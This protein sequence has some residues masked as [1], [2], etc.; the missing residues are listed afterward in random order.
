MLHSHGV[1]ADF[2]MAERTAETRKV[3]DFGKPTEKRNSHEQSYSERDLTQENIDLTQ[4]QHVLI[5]ET[6]HLTTDISVAG[7]G[8]RKTKVL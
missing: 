3:L 8:E 1:L 7:L 2:G 6:P 5:D 4:T